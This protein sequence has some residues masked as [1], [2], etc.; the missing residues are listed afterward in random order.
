MTGG[1]EGPENKGRAFHEAKHDHPVPFHHM[2]S[3]YEQVAFYT[4]LG[5]CCIPV[6]HR[7]KIPQQKRGWRQQRILPENIPK[8]YSPT[9]QN[10]GVVLGEPSNY[11][12]DVD[13]D[14][15]EANRA[16]HLFLPPTPLV[17][18]RPGKPDSHHLFRGN[19]SKLKKTRAFRLHVPGS[20]EPSVVLELRTTGGMTV[21]PPS[22]HSTGEEIH[23]TRTDHDFAA[24]TIDEAELIQRAGE[25]AA[26]L[27][28]A[29]YW[30]SQ[31]SR[32]DYALAAAGGMLRLGVLPDRVQ[33]IIR[34][35]AE[36]GHDDEPR[37]RE[38]CVQRT[39][40]KLLAGEE[41]TGLTKLA[42]I[43]G[44]PLGGRLAEAL[45]KWLGGDGQQNKEKTADRASRLG[46]TEFG[47]MEKFIEQRREVLRWDTDAERWLWWDKTCWRPGADAEAHLECQRSLT[48]L[49]AWA[50]T[51]ADKDDR[52]SAVAWALASRTSKM[53]EV[54]LR[55]SR[56][57]LA[58]SSTLINRSPWL[59]NVANG[60]LDLRTGELNPFDP[61][62]LITYRVDV[63]YDPEAP[64]PRWEQFI[65]EITMGDAELG[66]YLQLLGGY[67]LTGDAT[68]RCFFILEGKGND[69][70]TVFVET[71]AT[72]LGELASKSRVDTFLAGDRS[73]STADLARLR[74]TRLTWASENN[75]GSRLDEAQIKEL[76]GGDL[77]AARFLYQE[78]F[79]FAPSFKLLLLVNNV[80]EIRGQDDGI[81]NRVRVIPFH[82]NLDPDSPT[83]DKRL[84]DKLNLELSGILRWA[85]EGCREWQK[86][87]R[88]PPPTRVR[89]ETDDYLV[90]MN[91]FGDFI[92]EKLN[93]RTEAK[94]P[95]GRL[96]D[97][98][99]SWCELRHEEPASRKIFS[100]MMRERGFRS[101]HLRIEGRVQRGFEGVELATAKNTAE[102]LET[103]PVK[104][105]Y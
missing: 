68:E 18:G 44:E 60:T 93:V 23:W 8:H 50:L 63:A 30:P 13:L 72:L 86:L 34:A 75:R 87:G 16:A 105:P 25:L 5:W 9:N 52:A 99:I 33:L 11:L 69:G 29:R 6:E 48:E 42:E 64:A 84:R 74:H 21:I 26:T 91:W 57:H 101:K 53:V 92:K 27:A 45:S 15:P 47:N 82:L 89:E 66:R 35:A 4:A 98:Y 61:L 65:K 3:I 43:V 85:V 55:L 36:L 90:E 70:K 41:A 103:E 24:P 100:M 40:E 22:T 31:G 20:A 88:L 28:L 37:M 56:S 78:S 49:Y 32:Q 38:E 77:I 95:F 7:T 39:H 59:L 67:C 71:L 58:L 104:S 10:V 80:P 14:W 94:A 76:T 2:K 102:P 46:L 81:R 79:Q 19:G 17:F 54:V 62:D 1:A 96:Y 12:I 51:L 83:L 73:R 97:T